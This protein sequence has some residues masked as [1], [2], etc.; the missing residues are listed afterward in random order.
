MCPVSYFIVWDENPS[1][2]ILESI[3]LVTQ[4]GPSSDIQTSAALVDLVVTY[5][6][7]DIYIA[8]LQNIVTFIV[9]M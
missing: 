5:F 1:L 9:K 8:V 3:F 6:N 4:G 7:I 2:E